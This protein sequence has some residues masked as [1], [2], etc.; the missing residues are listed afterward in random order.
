M[1]RVRVTFWP[2][3]GIAG[4]IALVLCGLGLAMV[5]LFFVS[6]A[7]HAIPRS[8][9]LAAILFLVAL[10][11]VVLGIV[12]LRR[13]VRALSATQQTGS[14]KQTQAQAQRSL[15]AAAGAALLLV[16]G[17][18]VFPYMYEPW[19]PARGSVQ[20]GD[21][22]VEPT[23]RSACSPDAHRIFYKGHVVTKVA[24]KITFSPRNPAR[25]LYTAACANDGSESGVFYLDG[26]RGAPVQANPLGMDEP[27]DWFNQ[28]WSPDDKF[29]V[30]PAYG[31]ATLVDLQTGQRSKFLS[32]LFS[33]KD[34]ISSDAQ[35]GGWSPDGK[36]LAVIISSSYM[37]DDRSLL[38]ESD[39]VSI[40]PTTLQ[41]SYV[42]TIRRRDSWNSGE[43][44]WIA[45]DGTYDLAVD[46]S[47]QN[48]PT[49][50]H[51]V[52]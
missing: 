15:Y 37:P 14:Q 25:L 34:A 32:D 41:D 3:V 6:G 33:T 40:D 1:G 17:A 12:L 19:W 18:S 24:K 27:G 48:D 35:F 49:I 9:G 31:H 52:R 43:F 16:I 51:K 7:P 8:P 45:R 36:K 4:F 30:V 38:R 5:A 23:L 13:S 2:V 28:F 10:L 26:A 50:Y 11:F 44:T 46:S 29:V 21:Y 39:L 20:H 47:L 22:M 42:A